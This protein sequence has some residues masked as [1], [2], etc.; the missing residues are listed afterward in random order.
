MKKSFFERTLKG[1]S[2]SSPPRPI[3]D[4]S[5]SSLTERRHEARLTQENLAEL[6]GV[7][8][9]TVGFWEQGRSYPTL[10]YV[11]KLQEALYEELRG[12]RRR[13]QAWERL[14]QARRERQD[15]QEGK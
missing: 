1:I 7:S 5:G 13:E 11:A 15:A 9:Q 14:V 6:V 3:K 12:V 8:R 2:K 10:T 4:Y